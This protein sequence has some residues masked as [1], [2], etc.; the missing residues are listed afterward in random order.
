MGKNI[1]IRL[2]A[3]VEGEEFYGSSSWIESAGNEDNWV[4][5]ASFLASEAYDE[6]YERG[7]HE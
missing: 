3:S 5:L 4:E 2:T 6:Y 1:T 7:L